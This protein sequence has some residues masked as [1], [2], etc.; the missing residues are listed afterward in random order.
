MKRRSLVLF[1]PDFTKVNL[2]RQC[3]TIVIACE[4]DAFR[5]VFPYG[6][7]KW[8]GHTIKPVSPAKRTVAHTFAKLMRRAVPRRLARHMPVLKREPLP[9][10]SAMIAS[11]DTFIV[12]D[13]SGT[14]I[15][16]IEGSS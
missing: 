12:D 3:R 8:N 15:S 9:C 1:F 4:N 2:Q 10:Y 6:S 11:K 7:R 14:S 5:R 16:S 13:L